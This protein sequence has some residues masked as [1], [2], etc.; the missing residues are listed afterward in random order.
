MSTGFDRNAN[1]FTFVATA[2]V[3]HATNKNNFRF[4]YIAVHHQLFTSSAALVQH[5]Q[6]KTLHLLFRNA[7]WI[8]GRGERSAQYDIKKQRTR[9]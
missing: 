9:N 7:I 2:D 5:N 3:F 4:E 6:V 1:W 8:N